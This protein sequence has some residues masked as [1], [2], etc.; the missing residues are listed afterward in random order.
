LRFVADKCTGCH[1]CEL[2]CSA[3]HH[4]VF[5]PRK[6]YLNVRSV[7]V[8]DGLVVAARLCTGCNACVDAC[9][10]GA[11]VRR[12]GGYVVQSD[13]CTGCGSCAEACP[14][15]VVRISQ[16]VAGMCDMC[17]DAGSPQCVEWCRPGALTV[18]GSA[19]EAVGS[20]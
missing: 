6:A 11:V 14:E 7:Y 3:A 16:G 12:D 18:V 2:A 4:G 10:T 20:R 17:A 15:Q 1:L 5:D 13:L 8:D 9:P 19:G